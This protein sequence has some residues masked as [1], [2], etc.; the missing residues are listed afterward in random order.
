MVIP[1]K[2]VKP[3]AK[4]IALTGVADSPLGQIADVCITTVSEE[5]N[6]RT[7]AMITR[8]VQFVVIETLFTAISV[9]RGPRGLDRLSKTRQSLSYLKY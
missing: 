2:R 1:L 6:Y 3:F 9:R 7:D 4:V 8:I 5:M